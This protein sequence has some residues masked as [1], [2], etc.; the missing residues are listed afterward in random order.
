MKMNS[1]RNM[2]ANR[3]APPASLLVLVVSAILVASP[4]TNAPEVS[5]HHQV[6]S[7]LL[8]EFPYRLG[9]WVGVDVVLPSAATAIL[10]PNGY[11]NRRYSQIGKSNDVVLGIIHCEDI[12]DMDGHYP[13]RCYPAAGWSQT[14]ED[15]IALRIEDSQ[16]TMKLY[17]FQRAT[18]MGLVES[19]SVVSVFVAPDVGI[20]T[21]MDS[22]KKIGDTSLNTSALGVA[23]IQLVFADE[24]PTGII[25]DQAN[26]IF[27]EFPE[28]TIAN[29]MINPLRIVYPKEATLN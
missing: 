26:D 1:T 2:R 16:A 15:D 8:D 19:K 11:V 18:Q 28:N 3:L 24:L 22:L 23:Q 29:F 17:R 14:G 13:P 9:S 4:R 21:S 6:I 10:R 25:Q 5:R 12:R 20:L 27:S 7:K